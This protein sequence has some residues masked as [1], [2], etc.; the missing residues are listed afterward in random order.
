[1][2]ILVVDDEKIKR[3]TLSDDLATQGHEVETACDGQEAID[4]LSAATFDVVVSDLKMPNVDGIELLKWIKQ[5]PLAH[6]EVVMMTAYGSIEVAV[7][8]VKLGA[9]DFVT[10][11]FRNDDIFPLLARIERQ[12][13]EK[14]VAG[15]RAEAEAV[16]EAP[17]TDTIVTESPSMD[18][19][20]RMIEIAARTDANVLL[21]GETGVGK[22]LIS[23][24][25]H[26]RSHRSGFPYVKVG[27]TLF[28]PQLIESELYGHEKGSFTG[29][30][31]KR[32]GR[33]D[34]A[35]GGT[36]YL[37]DVDDI[38]LEQ[39]SKLLR[40][41][42][43]KVFEK[44]GGTVPIQADVRVIAST[45]QN[46]L[47]KIN[48]ALVGL[49]YCHVIA[50]RKNAPANVGMTTTVSSDNN[51][52]VWQTL[53]DP[54][55][56]LTS[57]PQVA[58]LNGQPKHRGFGGQEGVN[59]LVDVAFKVGDHFVAVPQRH[60]LCRPGIIRKRRS[61]WRHDRPAHVK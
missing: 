56:H 30:E 14:T 46:L 41:I 27:C 31:S 55:D 7:E 38:P 13:K 28:P 15:T 1:M 32:K 23:S 2:R 48:E 11:P 50:L 12:Q 26:R 22:D 45:K 44:V 29:A 58:L 51:Y 24:V 8:A 39:Q 10:K 43:E 37:D 52:Q 42:E 59:Y 17:I 21:C 18:R 47:D 6:V 60:V 5:G 4:R 20:V 61:A 49:A 33:F 36:L 9:F 34:L 35:Q 57:E 54:L 25:I 53:S 16:D 3:V 40:A 19:V